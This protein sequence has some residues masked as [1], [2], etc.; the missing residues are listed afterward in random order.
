MKKLF[1]MLM[2]VLTMN[3]QA[4]SKRQH[5]QDQIGTGV[6][7]AGLVFSVIAITVPDGGEFTYG[8]GYNSNKITKP[9]YQC[10]NRTIMLGIGVTL[11]V[12]GLIYQHNNRKYGR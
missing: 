7:I 4:Q 12:G 2:L 5:S 9:F 10:P 11:S 8:H 3:L 1:L 6:A